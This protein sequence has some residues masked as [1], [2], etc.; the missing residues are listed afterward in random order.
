M[1]GFVT[2]VRYMLVVLLVLIILF[3]TMLLDVYVSDEL[4]E[5]CPPKAFTLGGDS[6]PPY[7][8][9]P[10]LRAASYLALLLSHIVAVAS[11]VVSATLLAPAKKASTALYAALI[12]TWIVMGS[13]VL[14]SE[15]DAFDLPNY[16]LPAQQLVVVLW[17][18]LCVYAVHRRYGA[19]FAPTDDET[20][21]VVILAAFLSVPYLM[22]F[23]LSFGTP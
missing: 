18:A 12:T 17:A 3:S 13:A 4:L 10:R 8:T 9:D 21:A 22:V 2:A 7:C 1:Q 5:R 19:D 23:F 16:A 20:A 6:T 15:L 11:I 14:F